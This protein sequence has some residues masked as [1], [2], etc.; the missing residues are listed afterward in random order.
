MYLNANTIAHLVCGAAL[1]AVPIHPLFSQPTAAERISQPILE[2]EN[3]TIMPVVVVTGDHEETFLP[4]QIETGSRLEIAPRDQVNTLHTVPRVLLEQRAAVSV[5]DAVESLPGV[6]VVSPSYTSSS[7]GIRS[8]GFEAFDTFIDGVRVGSFGTSLD[9]SVIE[10]LEVLK[11]PAG[12]QFGLAE[13]G[14][15]LNVITRAPMESPGFSLSGTVGSYDLYRGVLDVG[16]PFPGTNDAL[17]T[18][19]TLAGENSAAWRDFDEAWKIAPSIAFRLDLTPDT[20]FTA[21]AMYLYEEFRFNRGLTPHP[22]ILDVPYHRS[23]MEPNLPMS[24][25]HHFGF[26]SNLT[27]RFG[28]SGWVASQRFGYF[29]TKGEVHEI[30]LG[31]GDVDALGNLSRNYFFSEN[32]QEYLTLAHDV[33]TRFSTGPVEHRVL[34]GLELARTD[35]GYGFYEPATAEGNPAP[36]NAAN[37]RYAGYTPPSRGS[38]VESYAPEQYGNE[39]IGIYTDYQMIPFENLRILAGA[40]FDWASGFYETRDGSTSYPAAN[41]FGFSPRVGFVYSP[42]QP[43]DLYA[44]YSTG[45]SPNLFADGEGNTFSDP[46]LSRQFEGG[47]RY[48]L[49]PDRLQARA[50]A[51]S[52]RKEN[53]QVPDP[54]DPT[55]NR[56]ILSGENGS[57]GFEIDLTGSIAPG[58]DINLGYSYLDARVTENTDSSQVGLPLVGSP[59]NQVTLWTRY[60]FVDGPLKNFWAGYGLTYV[61]SRRSSFANAAFDLP[62]YV[63]HD[64]GIGYESDN[65]RAQLN[66]LNF[67]SDRVYE[68]HGNNIHLQAPIEVRASVTFEF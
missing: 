30:N 10:R 33:Q 44:N 43:L 64:A 12:V 59:Q 40:R 46:E 51:F 8:R 67:T 60:K 1:I 23:Y 27:H 31:V 35:F 38:L 37:P 18:R 48:Q 15:T 19:F 9:S 41:S 21:R 62:S 28:D 25:G 14:G 26:L 58:W 56:S 68:T 45:F 7:I 61:D 36:I 65:W 17:A 5:E 52:I 6:T 42:V 57:D 53:V 66:V 20:T 55:G 50:S 3:A 29:V 11:G 63:K 47:V 32:E 2:A 34:V 49:I 39:L 4:R 54:S 24:H 13:P 22:Y 16:G